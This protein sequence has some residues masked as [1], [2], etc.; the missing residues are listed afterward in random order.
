MKIA[1]SWFLG[2]GFDPLLAVA[3]PNWG[4]ARSSVHQR[5]TRYSK[6]E[7]LFQIVQRDKLL[8]CPMERSNISPFPRFGVKVKICQQFQ[9]KS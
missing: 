5:P 1:D 6:R 4:N 8:I 3:T 9:S 7:I 2:V